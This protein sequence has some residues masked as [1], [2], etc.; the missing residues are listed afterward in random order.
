MADSMARKL[1]LLILD[2]DPSMVRLLTRVVEYNLADKMVA[3]GLTEPAQAR[4]W[5]EKNCCDI[6][7]SD[8]E[9]PGTDG[10]EMLRFAKRQNAWTQVIFVTAHSTWDRVAEAV[11]FGASDY[12]LKP[13]DTRDL[14]ALLNQ[15]YVRCVRW[16]TA[17]LGTLEA[18]AAEW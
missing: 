11:E 18:V 4:D 17:V 8:L 7:I 10:L 12:L 16:Q 15:Q 2:D 9:M 14:I 3:V 6:L 5:L 13:I 1:N